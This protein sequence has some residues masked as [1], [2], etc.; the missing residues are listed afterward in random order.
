MARWRVLPIRTIRTRG[1][2]V[3]GKQQ[4]HKPQEYCVTRPAAGRLVGE[5][6][7]EEPLCRG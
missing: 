5:N 3:N 1:G 6:A 7:E 2:T 4:A